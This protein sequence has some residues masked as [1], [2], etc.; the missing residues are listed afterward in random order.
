MLKLFP[1]R[2]NPTVKPPRK[3]LTYYMDFLFNVNY[4]FKINHYCIR[5]IT[6]THNILEGIKN[7]YQ[8]IRLT[9]IQEL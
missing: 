3:L 5:C 6:Y 8:V 2:L 1:Y 9:K 4:H 7:V